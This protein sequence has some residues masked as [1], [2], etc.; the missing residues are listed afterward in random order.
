MS[1]LKSKRAQRVV[2]VAGF[3]IPVGVVFLIWAPVIA[4]YHV[5]SI[6]ISDAMLEAA[7]RSPSDSL[8]RLLD[9][10]RL[11]ELRGRDQ[12][13]LVRVAEGLL[14]GVAE[15]P[16]FPPARI[17]M[18]FDPHDLNTPGWQLLLAGL[19]VPRIL[20]D[21]YK[22][23]GREEFFVQARDVIVAF[24]EYQ[25]RASLPRGL[26]WNDHAIAARIGVLTEFW[27]VYRMRQDYT[28]V[29]GR[30][31]LKQAARDAQLLS[32]PRRFT[33]STNHGVMQNLALL[34]FSLAFPALPEVARYKRLALSRL[35]EQMA[36]Y[37][38]DDGVVLEHSAGYQAFGL[39]LI[40]M[41]CGYLTLGGESIPDDWIQTYRRA[42]EVLSVLRRPDGSL[43]T[44]GDTDD[45][46]DD[47]GPRTP[48][49]K[50]R[51]ACERSGDLLSWIPK[52][53]FNLY[54]TAGYSIWWD[55]LSEWPRQEKM[56]QTVVVWSYFPEHAH[57]HADEMSVLVWAGGTAWW[58]NVGYWPYWDAWR[59]EAES[60][61]G[62]SAP[63]LAQESAGSSRSTTLLAYGR[64]DRL[65]AIDLER[66]GPGQY[67]A[68]RQV[69]HVGSRAWLVADYVSGDDTGT[70]AVTWTASPDVT[71]RKGAIPGSYI[72]AAPHSSAVL[73]T[74]VFGSPGTSI[75]EFKGSLAPFAG[76]H[77]MN[78]IPRVAP[79]LV[80]QQPA[81][82]SWS[83]VTWMIDFNDVDSG[84]NLDNPRVL[85]W[86]SPLDWKAE[87]PLASEVIEVVREQDRIVVHDR[88][89]QRTVEV[90]PLVAAPDVKRQVARIH[91]TFADAA[92]KYPGFS[93]LLA[94]RAKT[95]L[96]L[97][98]VVA[99]QEACLFAIRRKRA[100]YDADIRVLTVFGWLGLGFWLAFFFLKA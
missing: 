45:P 94:R 35:R 6:T 2:R 57:K 100:G 82:N 81:R 53:P 67:V 88:R 56:G 84:R 29:V 27:R 5:S 54:P 1:W 38:D 52:R 36:F 98:I 8:L 87:I 97:L 18:P 61:S 46:G 62:A 76:W 22:Q 91:V 12:E 3:V 93:D 4:H 34:H 86:K 40:A 24:E 44:F 30:M 73:R 89:T 70:T 32:D 48:L 96:L 60:W 59:D 72:S 55:G 9:G 64:S 65:A 37:V 23:T 58:T 20:L 83:I 10:F 78:S 71:L 49:P 42:H 43:P 92:R 50:V 75:Q 85:Y 66:K 41:A 79:A 80:I 95:S 63:H 26:L 17:R 51:S 69:V 21:A 77:V 33:F 90:L 47:P 19:A 25:R 28:P 16:G 15:L 39:Q 14:R 13:Q 11:M 7:K 68:R 74:F 99:S 31:I